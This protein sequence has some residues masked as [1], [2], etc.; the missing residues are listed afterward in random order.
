LMKE[1]EDLGDDPHIFGGG[2]QHDHAKYKAKLLVKSFNKPE[3]PK[4]EDLPSH[5][6]KPLSDKPEH[7]D[8]TVHHVREF[9]HHAALLHHKQDGFI[10]VLAGKKSKDGLHAHESYISQEHRKKGLGIALYEHAAEHHGGVISGS[11]L[12]DASQR[13]YKHFAKQGRLVAHV[14]PYHREIDPSTRKIH[15]NP[16]KY[17]DY[18]MKFH[19]AGVR[20]F[21]KQDE[22]WRHIDMK[23]TPSSSKK[24]NEENEERKLLMT[25]LEFQDMQDEGGDLWGEDKPRREA[26]KFADRHK[27]KP[28]V[29][30]FDVNRKTTETPKVEAEEL[31]DH[32]KKPLSDKPEHADYTV[33]HVKKQT[34]SHDDHAL[35]LHHKKHGFIGMLS[36][37]KIHSREPLKAKES[38]ISRNHR[39]QGLGVALYEHAAEHHGGVVSDDSLS[40]GSQ[41]VYAHF[42]KQGR[43]VAH[44]SHYDIPAKERRIHKK[45]HGKPIKYDE[46]TKTFSSKGIKNYAIQKELKDSDIHMKIIPQKK[47]KE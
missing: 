47:S 10:G 12:T 36:G 20:D 5:S 41:R 44:A 9:L 28:A 6:T 22:H 27:A 32:I 7:A 34:I 13:I 14:D 37:E 23:I 21:T 11:S 39:G 19:T 15:G 24:K 4:P 3:N 2:S 30:D 38:Y 42:A 8:Y 16:I 17:D 18:G 25:F 31:H 46:K 40:Y 45:E 33:H 35:L 1:Y 26:I 29:R 43:L